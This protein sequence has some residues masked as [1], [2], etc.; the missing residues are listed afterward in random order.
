MSKSSGVIGSHRNCVR[1]NADYIVASARQRFCG[2]RRIEGS[3]SWLWIKELSKRRGNSQAVKEYRKKWYEKNRARL[4][5]N[6]RIKYAANRVS[7][8]ARQVA[9][10]TQRPNRYKRL[11][12]IT[13]D[14]YDRLFSLQHG[15]CAICGTKEIDKAKRRKYFCVDHCHKSGKVRGLLCVSCNVLLGQFELK[16]R[17]IIRYLEDSGN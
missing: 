9:A 12:G 3:C 5:A 6:S 1:C 7:I 14:D 16:K 4:S 17:A 13:T 2:S 10:N 8:L 15:G 11:Y